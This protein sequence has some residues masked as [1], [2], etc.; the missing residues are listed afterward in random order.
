MSDDSGYEVMKLRFYQS[1]LQVKKIQFV[2][3]K[4][5]LSPGEELIQP[6]LD[7]DNTVWIG[8]FLFS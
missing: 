1:C 5:D 7:F 2:L 8:W 4:L 3:F 6:S